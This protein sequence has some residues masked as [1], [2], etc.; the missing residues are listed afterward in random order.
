MM[1]GGPVSPRPRRTRRLVRGLS[2]ILATLAL[3]LVVIVASLVAAA[4][5][6]PSGLVR[7]SPFL[8]PSPYPFGRAVA[9]AHP[10]VCGARAAAQ[11]ATTVVDPHLLQSESP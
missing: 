5:P 4:A 6:G 9:P 11:F 8:A 7:S 3:G 1:R 10:R 2:L